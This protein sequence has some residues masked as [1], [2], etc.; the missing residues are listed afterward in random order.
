MIR[1]LRI[2]RGGCNLSDA[3]CC[4]A[5]L[6]GREPKLPARELLE[7]AER[8]TVMAEKSPVVAED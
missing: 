8:V 1:M 6:A 4:R 2:I 3:F 7:L 5:H